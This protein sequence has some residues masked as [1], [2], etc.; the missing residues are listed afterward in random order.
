MLIPLSLRR[1]LIW[2]QVLLGGRGVGSLSRRRGAV[3]GEPL[4]EATSKA[5]MGALFISHG[6]RFPIPCCTDLTR[7]RMTVTNKGRCADQAPSL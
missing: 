6:L 4:P 5:A 2:F 7:P 1:N 3:G